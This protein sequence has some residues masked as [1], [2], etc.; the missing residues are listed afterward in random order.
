MIFLITY[1]FQAKIAILPYN[2]SVNISVSEI[3]TQP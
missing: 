1:T 2:V 3:L